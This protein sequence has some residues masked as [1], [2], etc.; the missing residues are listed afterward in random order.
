MRCHL[1]AHCARG[2]GA[3]NQPDRRQRSRVMRCLRGLWL[4][5]AIGVGLTGCGDDPEEVAAGHYP[6]P[7]R[8]HEHVVPVARALQALCAAATAPAARRVAP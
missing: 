5:A 3:V 4:G 7:I 6:V 2:P 1:S 8:F